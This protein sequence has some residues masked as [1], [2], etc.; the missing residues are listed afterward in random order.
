MNE[1]NYKG[2]GTRIRKQR[3]LLGYTR[4][5]LAEKLDVSVKF[6]SDIELGVKGMSMNTLMNISEI[7]CLNVDYILFGDKKVS[8]NELFTVEALFSQCP[9]KYRHNLVTIMRTFVESV[10]S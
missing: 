8:D 4:E 2:I 1:I 6:C 10:K 3:E 7:L 5:N 9:E